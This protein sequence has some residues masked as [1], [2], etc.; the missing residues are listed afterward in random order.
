[1]AIVL[2]TLLIALVTGPYPWAVT[3]RGWV[4]DG[5]RGIASA[6]GGHEVPDTGRVGW[7]RDHRDAL[8]LGGAIVLVA[9]LLLVDLS[10][11]GFVTVGILIALYE[12]ALWR[13]G[14]EPD[15]SEM[16]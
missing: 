2:L 7:L 3:G 13:L 6:F 14:H 15:G 10:L 16:A 12:L 4:R 5:A 11:W 8:M 1:L 9:L